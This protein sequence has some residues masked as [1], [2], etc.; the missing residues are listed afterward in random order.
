MKPYKT[1][2]LDLDGTVFDFAASEKI[3]FFAAAEDL[4]LL[5]TCEEYSLYSD[6]NQ[7][8]WTMLERKEITIDLLRTERFRRLLE[9]TGKQGDPAL[10][11]KRYVA[12]LA[13]SVIP[14]EGAAEFC[15][16][17]AARYSLCVV[18]N[19]IRHNQY[20][21]V[22]LSPIAP[23]V[24]AMVT[25]E[26]IGAAK[27]SPLIFEEALRRAGAGAEQCVMIGDNFQAD[28]LG[29]AD[30]GIDAIWYADAQQRVDHN[31]IVLV[32]QSYEAILQYLG[33]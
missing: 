26:E 14:F 30:C 20:Q 10:F 33:A 27:P 17:L 3:C 15:R 8:L 28:I 22:K 9:Q 18:T 16:R 1:V 13:Q 23:Y 11:A 12:H 21:R 31:R 6:I 5:F 29:A 24:T 25:S 2:L 32:S 4:D 19:G 7:K